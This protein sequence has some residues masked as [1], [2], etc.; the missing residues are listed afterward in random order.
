MICSVHSYL[1]EVLAQGISKFTL[2][3]KDQAYQSIQLGQPEAFAGGAA[4]P[5]SRSGPLE[6]VGTF[7]QANISISGLKEEF[8]RRCVT[9]IDFKPLHIVQ[10]D[11]RNCSLLLQVPLYHV[12]SNI[13]F[14]HVSGK[15]YYFF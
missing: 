10:L 5:E 8:N 11:V 1:V 12:K 4:G 2:M 14:V 15:K 13:Q 7:S 9:G 3:V 6:H